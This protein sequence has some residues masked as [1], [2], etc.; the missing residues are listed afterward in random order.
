MSNLDSGMGVTLLGCLRHVD[1]RYEV[2]ICEFLSGGSANAAAARE[3]GAEV[4]E[5]GKPGV[6]PTILADLVRTA[7]RFKPHVVQGSELETNFYACLVGRLVGARVV[8]GFHGL[9]S[10]FRPSMAPFLYGVLLGAHRIVCVSRAVAHLCLARVPSAGRRLLLIPNG[11]DADRFAPRPSGTA[12]GRPVVT[13]VA[14]LYSP[15]KG[16]AYLLRGLSMLEEAEAELWLVGDGALLAPMQSLAR[17]LGIEDRVTF[18]GRRDDV[19]TLLSRSDVFALPSL[20]ESCP[21]ALLE[22]MA[23]GLPVVATEVGGVPEIVQDGVTGRL[24]A[25]RDAIGLRDAIREVTRDAGLRETLRENALRRV[26]EA[27]SERDAARR[28]LDLYVSLTAGG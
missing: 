26:R 12:S 10:A 17:E 27:Y 9:E 14:N 6:D 16:H 13:C 18:W 21:H 1:R 20:S 28:Y 3:L 24:V 15:V 23:A 22:A 19:A 5:L 25:P 2:L 7:R 8:A 4:I 11:V